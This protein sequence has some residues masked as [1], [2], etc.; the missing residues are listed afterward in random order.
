M[1]NFCSTSPP[2]HC[3]HRFRASQEHARASVSTNAPAAWGTI[4]Q[5]LPA[6]SVG[7]GDRT[8]NTHAWGWGEGCSLRLRGV[9]TLCS[10]R[11]VDS[12]GEPTSDSERRVTDE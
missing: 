3:P 7:A 5:S 12:A 2:S 8:G 4:T 9:F 11:P 6:S 10:V 1:C